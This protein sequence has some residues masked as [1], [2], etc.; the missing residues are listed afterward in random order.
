LT[1]LPISP[2]AWYRHLEAEFK[3]DPPLARREM[4]RST[5]HFELESDLSD[6]LLNKVKV[7]HAAEVVDPE[8]IK[9]EIWGWSRR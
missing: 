3:P 8:T 5:Y 7:L 1:K 2:G 9:S 6:Y 4:L